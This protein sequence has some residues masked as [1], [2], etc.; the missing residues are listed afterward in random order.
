MTVALVIGGAS[1]IGAACATRLAAA[2]RTVLVAD[3]DVE[4]GHEVVAKIVAA[5]GS[6]Q[7]RQVDVREPDGVRDLVAGVTELGILVNAAGISGPLRLLADY[8]PDDYANVLRTNL[9]GVFHAMRAALPIM[10]DR[11]GGVIVNIA[12]IAGS[13]AF[14]AHS[15]YVAAKHGVIGLTKAGAREYAHLGIRVVSVSPGLITSPMTDALPSGTRDRVVDAVP[16]RRAGRPE[17]VAEVV[18]FLCSDAASYVNGSDHPVDGGYL[19]Q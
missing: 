13:S 6:A 17:E 19:T 15:A 1:G 10:C 9:D 2:D 11:G 5:G 12:S 14:R 3:L 8:P 18:A 4:R 7:A 16:S